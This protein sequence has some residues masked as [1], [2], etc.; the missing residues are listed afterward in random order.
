[1]NPDY[2]GVLTLLVDEMAEIHEMIETGRFKLLSSKAIL[3]ELYKIMS[4]VDVNACM[5]R[6]NHASNYF[7]LAGDLPTDKTRLLEEIE[8]AIQDQ[9]LLKSEGLRAL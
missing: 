5:F 6:S 1:M 8:E 3:Q 9:E 4:G 2:I 7:A